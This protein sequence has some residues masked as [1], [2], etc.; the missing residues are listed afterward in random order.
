MYLFR[1][2]A[3]WL[4]LAVISQAQYR[5]SLVFWLIHRLIEP[6]IYLSIWTAVAR[7]N[8]GAVEAYHIQDFI[9]YYVVSLVVN[10]LTYT[11]HIA[12]YD[13]LIRSGDIA[14]LLLRPTHP[15]HADIADNLASKIQT[16][17]VMLPT[18][19]LVAILYQPILD[20]RWL[21]AFLV[22]V[23]LA[24]ATR[25]LVEYALGLL[26]FWTVRVNAIS[27]LYYTA[28]LFLSGKLAPFPLLPKAIQ[29]IALCLPFYWM[30]GFPIEILLGQLDTTEILRG[31]LIQALYITISSL[32]I[33]CLWRAGIRRYTA[34]GG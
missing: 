9:N 29:S 6:I 7:A 25:F 28:G 4:K 21:P 22:A 26:A 27:Q 24:F 1:L 3:A 23:L 12:W 30:F 13:Y 10:H 19:A 16:V 15:I 20:L 34:V 11:W 17:L 18:L 33:D 5:L 2:Y 31:Y 8:G 32:F 14:A